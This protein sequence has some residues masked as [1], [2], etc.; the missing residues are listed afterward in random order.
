MC[1]FPNSHVCPLAVERN[2]ARCSNPTNKPD[3]A[4]NAC[5]AELMDELGDV[6]LEGDMSFFKALFVGHVLDREG[7]IGCP[8]ED[9][10][11]QLERA[12]SKLKGHPG[13]CAIGAISPV[14]GGGFRLFIAIDDDHE[15][16]EVFNSLEDATT[17]YFD[18]KE[19]ID[20]LAKP[21]GKNR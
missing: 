18:R 1:V 19:T 17:S 8:D 13:D 7:F 4:C 20:V 6:M 12:Q 3:E 11:I 2:G 21:E 5:R 14:L 9:G 10:G 16:S 15:I